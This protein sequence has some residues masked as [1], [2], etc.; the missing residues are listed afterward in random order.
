[1]SGNLVRTSYLSHPED[2]NYSPRSI[3][4]RSGLGGSRVGDC[5]QILH[6]SQYNYLMKFFSG[7][8]SPPE[9][10]IRVTDNQNFLIVQVDYWDTDKWKPCNKGGE[11]DVEVIDEPNPKPHIVICTATTSKIRVYNKNTEQNK[12]AVLHLNEVEVYSPKGWSPSQV[13]I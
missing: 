11:Q 9:Q 4:C 12:W 8:K 6:I 7:S 10:N 2:Q 1:M 3:K 13:I 5:E